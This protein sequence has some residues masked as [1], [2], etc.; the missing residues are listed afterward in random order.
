ML[1]ICLLLICAV[2]I[3]VMFSVRGILRRRRQKMC[4]QIL[5]ST[6]EE[7]PVERSAEN[8]I[9][10]KLPA[11]ETEKRMTQLKEYLDSGL[12]TKEEYKA[13]RKALLKE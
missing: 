2:Y 4:A 12:I 7:E 1:L 8:S 11:D 6:K 5:A 13:R 10:T 3:I 9:Q